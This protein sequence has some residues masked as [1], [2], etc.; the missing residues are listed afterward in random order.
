MLSELFLCSLK[1]FRKN[2]T[3]LQK[4]FEKRLSQLNDTVMQQQKQ[5]L[6]LSC[7]RHQLTF[8]L[9]LVITADRASAGPAHSCH[10]IDGSGERFSS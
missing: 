1:K 4:A 6:Y 7:F 5:V 2:S 9:I 3:D 10:S 8:F